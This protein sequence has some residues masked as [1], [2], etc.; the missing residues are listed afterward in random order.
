MDGD[1]LCECGC[2]GLT[3]LAPDTNKKRGW[4]K[5]QPRRFIYGHHV[6]KRDKHPSWRGGVTK[7]LSVG[8]PGTRLPDH[9]NARA[10]GYVL[11]HVLA[12]SKALGKPVPPNAVVHHHT[13]TPEQLVICENQGYHQLLH[14]RTRALRACGHADWLKCS[15]CKVYDDPSHLKIYWRDADQIHNIGVHTACVQ[16]RNQQRYR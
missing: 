3:N 6:A 4:V 16:R 2:G 9:P 15:Y 1:G 8:Y 12:A 14:R 13:H 7:N 11:S 5:G 10:N